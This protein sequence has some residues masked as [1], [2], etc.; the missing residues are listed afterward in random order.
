MLIVKYQL[1]DSSLRSF[2][3]GSKRF[4]LHIWWTRTVIEDDEERKYRIY[5]F[6]DQ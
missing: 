4:R 6:S 3:V 1:W 5:F 2:T